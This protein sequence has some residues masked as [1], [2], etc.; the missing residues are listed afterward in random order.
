MLRTQLARGLARGPTCP[1]SRPTRSYIANQGRIGRTG[2]ALRARL[3]R[4]ASGAAAGGGRR[5]LGLGRRRTD[6]ALRRARSRRSRGGRRPALVLVDRR[7]PGAAGRRCFEPGR[8]PTCAT[9]EFQG[10][11]G[12]DFTPLLRRGR[13][14]TVPISAWC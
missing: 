9:I 10:G 1:W 6:G 5:C 2:A 13:H 11:G 3:H 14:A 12:T 8:R 7:R 4:R